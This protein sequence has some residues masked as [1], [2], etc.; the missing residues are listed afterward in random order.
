MI[1]VFTALRRGKSARQNGEQARRRRS[2]FASAMEDR[3][4]G[5]QGRPNCFRLKSKIAFAMITHVNGQLF[6]AVSRAI[7]D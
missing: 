5:G 6:C 3:D 4:Y 7:L 1:P 2:S